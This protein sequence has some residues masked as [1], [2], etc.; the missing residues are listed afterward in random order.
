MAEATAGVTAGTMCASRAGISSRHAGTS[1]SALAC[2]AVPAASGDFSA[3]T[4]MSS[5]EMMTFPV[6]NG[7]L[8]QLPLLARDGAVVPVKGDILNVYYVARKG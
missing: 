8:F 5:G 6:Y 7:E 2:G 4:V 1:E 3:A